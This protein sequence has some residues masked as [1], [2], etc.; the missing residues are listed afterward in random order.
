MADDIVKEAVEAFTVAEEVE[1]DNRASYLDDTKFARLGEQWPD[2]IKKQRTD[3]GRPCLALD[4]LQAIIRQVVNDARQNRPATVV[5]PCDSNGDPETAEVLSGMIRN[6]E[7]SSDADVA[8]DTAVDCAVSGGFG[9]W[10]INTDYAINAVDEDG[11]KSAGEGL[12]DQ[13]LFIRRI[14]NPLSIYGDPYSVEAD[15]S[16][17]NQAHEVEVMTLKQFQQKY[18]DAI[19]TDFK[20]ERW[21]GVSTPWRDGDNVMV[22]GYW[23]R[24]KVIRKAYAVELGPDENGV[25]GE[26][27]IMLEDE[28][29]AQR[30]LIVRTGGKIIGQPRPVNGFKVT[31]HI[32]SGAEL[33]ETNDWPGSYIPIIPV[34]GD[35]VNIEGK[36]HFR[37]L[38]NPAKDAQRNFN[39]WRTTMTETI[40]LAP[41]VPFIGRKGSFKTDAAKW[42]TANSHSHAYIEYDG[43]MPPQRQMSPQVAAG[44]LQE[45][46]NA[47]DDIKA[48]T[49]IYDASLGARSNETSG[50]AIMARQRE[51]DV[52]TYHFIDNLSRAIRHSGRVLVDLIP[53]VYS[54]ERIVRII[55]Q[56]G[57][58]SVVKV[59]GQIDQMAE[60]LPVHDIRTGR[61]DVTVKSGPSYSTRREETASQMVE[62][63]R[64]YPDI[65]PLISDLLAKNLDWPGAEEIAERLKKMLPPQLQGEDGP[66]IPP[67]VMA[68]FE[69]LRQAAQEMAQQLQMAEQD[70]TSDR[71]KLALDGEKIEIERY[72]AETDRMQAVQPSFDA[73]E[74]KSLVAQTLVDLLSPD[75]LPDAEDEDMG[76]SAE[77]EPDMAQ[78]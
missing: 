68:Q 28:L 24:E 27:V 59:N 38:I 32:V 11:I 66:Q 8:Y 67:E 61:Y 2:L 60:T 76:Q 10:K 72:K 6:I 31:H 47:A 19:A 4:R 74:V 71:A 25:P 17:W 73:Q 9:Y 56:D 22:A 75:D 70:R 52:S 29:K 64:A 62:L 50:K 14:A 35:E 55:A 30:E 63:I 37:S 1:R 57:E 77:A 36:R 48:I 13:N 12:F 23:K 53:K 16:D 21:E 54:T 15:S 65:A 41:R 34:Y 33:L 40:A 5:H 58:P 18:P 42:A 39:Y 49:G 78:I 51:G 44:A 45:V 43:D 46:L 20:S 3:E 69:Q 7:Q 26:I